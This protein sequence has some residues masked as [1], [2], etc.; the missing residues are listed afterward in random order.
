MN[1]RTRGIGSV[2]TVAI[3]LAVALMTAAEGNT[4]SAGAGKKDLLRFGAEMA[5]RGNWREARFRWQLVAEKRPE[6]AR[7]QNNLAVASEALGDPDAAGVHYERALSLAPG[8]PRILD[9]QIQFDRFWRQD[10]GDENDAWHRP[11]VGT[12]RKPDQSKGKKLRVSIQLPM[13]PRMDLEGIDTMLVASFLVPESGPLDVNRELVRFLRSE[14]RKH[15]D[16][17]RRFGLEIKDRTRGDH[18]LIS[19]GQDEARIKG[20]DEIE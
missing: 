5:S 4:T 10:T 1:G 17:D 11:T 18:D 16:L 14:F 13:P 6:D 12:G 8:D 20:G 3:C 15:S 7:I 9:N 19:I 2:A